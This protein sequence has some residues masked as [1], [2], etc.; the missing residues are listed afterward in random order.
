MDVT[1]SSGSSHVPMILPLIYILDFFT[2][3]PPKRIF[4]FDEIH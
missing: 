3:L 1:K 2:N 4:G